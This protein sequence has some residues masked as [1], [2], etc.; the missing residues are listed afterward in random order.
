MKK[1]LIAF[2]ILL[3]ADEVS[4]QQPDG[5]HLTYS[6]FLIGDAGEYKSARDDVLKLAAEQVRI[7]GEKSTIIFLGDN[8]YQKG[9]PPEGDPDR[10]Y[11]EGKLTPQLDVI[12]NSPGSGYIIP[13]NHDWYKSKEKGLAAIKEQG[14]FARDF[15]GDSEV[16]L[17]KDGCPG[18]I[19]VKLTEDIILVVI[20]SQWPLHKY[21]KPGIGSNCRYQTLEEMQ[22]GIDDIIKE[23]QTKKLIVAAHHPI[24]TY[25]NHAGIFSF[26]THVFPLTDPFGALFIPLPIVGSIYP[27]YRKV[28]GNDQDITGKLNRAV[29]NPI[30]KSLETHP[31]AIHVSGHEHALEHI[32]SNNVNYI[33]SGSGSKTEYVRKKKLA[34]YARSE[35]G[36]SRIN[37]YTSGE[38]WVEFWVVDKVK[39]KGYLDYEA[40]LFQSQN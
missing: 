13:G 10:K 38:A 9:L 19:D 8:I 15:T 26:K 30:R 25:G 6:V 31:M 1:S 35:N 40:I 29:M 39:P 28:I 23:N 32:V 5:S 27:I 22:K 33:V 20:D 12:I 21:N 3:F 34:K 18:P 17:P 14:K 37:F 36:F 24:Y 7:A 16:F 2:F 11:L 4:G